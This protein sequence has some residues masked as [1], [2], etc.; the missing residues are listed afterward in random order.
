MVERK[1]ENPGFCRISSVAVCQFSSAEEH[2]CGNE[3][4]L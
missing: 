3:A 1:E 4:Q 2:I